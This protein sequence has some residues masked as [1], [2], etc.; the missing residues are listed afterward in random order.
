[1]LNM[2]NQVHI[3]IDDIM[4]PKKRY[5]LNKIIDYTWLWT[6]VPYRSNQMT[7]PL[8]YNAPRCIEVFSFIKKIVFFT[9]PI[10]LL[11]FLNIYWIGSR[12]ATPWRRYSPT[13]SSPLLFISLEHFLTSPP[14]FK[15]SYSFYTTCQTDM[16]KLFS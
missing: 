14:R 7:F 1:M 2:T 11:F 4:F 13:L 8:C 5:S 12:Y 16:W 15:P 9:S 6:L 3:I 10:F